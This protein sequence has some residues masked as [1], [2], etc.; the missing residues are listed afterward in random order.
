MVRSVPWTNT[1]IL[2]FVGSGRFETKRYP[3]AT[4]GNWHLITAT[5]DRDG[6]DLSV[7]GNTQDYNNAAVEKFYIDGQLVEEK[8]V[9]TVKDKSVESGHPYVLGADG[10]HNLGIE[11]GYFDGLKVYKNALGA[12]EIRTLVCPFAVAPGGTTSLLLW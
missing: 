2:A 7:D 6:Y 10:L 5:V 9:D 1:L 11:N 3:D 4:D 8:N 12:A